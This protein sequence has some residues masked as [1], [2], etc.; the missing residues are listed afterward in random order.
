[1]EVDHVQSAILPPFG[2]L[3]DVSRDSY[4]Q[5]VWAQFEL[6]KVSSS[7]VVFR[8]YFDSHGLGTEVS[9]DGN[10]TRHMRYHLASSRE[11]YKSSL[12]ILFLTNSTLCLMIQF[13]ISSSSS[14]SSRHVRK[15]LKASSSSSVLSQSITSRIGSGASTTQVL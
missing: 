2:R 15:I 7:M 5:A 1:V 10:S 11:S 6:H 13:F 4:L 14:L 3:R 12:G 9:R 8:K